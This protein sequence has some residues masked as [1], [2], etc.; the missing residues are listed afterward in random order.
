M[1]VARSGL[2][3]DIRETAPSV[4]AISVWLHHRGWGVDR[5]KARS[6]R[7]GRGS[8][9]GALDQGRRADCR[10]EQIRRAGHG[11]PGKIIRELDDAARRPDRIG[12][13]L[14][15]NAA[16]IAGA[17]SGPGLR[18]IDPRICRRFCAR[19]PVAMLV[20]DER[21]AHPGRE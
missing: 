17:G 3:K 8:G 13:R 21:V 16:A 11:R 10:R 4:C 14:S 12:A 5:D 9:Q 7:T 15:K 2:S 19:F 18:M 20:V 6:S 1:S